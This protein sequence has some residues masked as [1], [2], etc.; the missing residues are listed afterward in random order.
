MKQPRTNSPERFRN[1]V[2]R[3]IADGRYDDALQAC[4]EAMD[5]MSSAEQ[6]RILDYRA[7]VEWEAGRKCDAINTMMEATKKNP[8]WAGHHYQIS[9]WLI[10]LGRYEDAVRSAD[11]LIELEQERQ[12]TAFLDAGLFLKSFALLRSGHTS[13]GRALLERVKDEQPVWI[14]GRLVSKNDLLGH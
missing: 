4:D 3:L 6:H 10:E 11:A 13:M 12:S 8:R 1:R 14:A 7:L 5:V 9:L 2:L